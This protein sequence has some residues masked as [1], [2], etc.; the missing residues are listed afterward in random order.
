MQAATAPM[1][2]VVDISEA[3]PPSPSKVR[4]LA[5]SFLH[6]TTTAHRLIQAPHDS[7]KANTDQTVKMVKA[8]ELQPSVIRSL[9]FAERGAS[10]SY[11]C[12]RD[13]VV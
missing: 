4:L 6:F 12:T 3:A 11:L 5:D 9:E 7:T 2:K 13:E 1:T 10:L 8:G